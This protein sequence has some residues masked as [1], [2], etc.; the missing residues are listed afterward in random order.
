MAESLGGA[1][2]DCFL[3]NWAGHGHRAARQS[4][5]ATAS[6][7][8]ENYLSERIVDGQVERTFQNPASMLY[9]KVSKQA[10]GYAQLSTC[11]SEAKALLG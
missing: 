8:N 2:T 10:G 6:G 7:T 11:A 1:P 5:A 9:N 4:P 3:G